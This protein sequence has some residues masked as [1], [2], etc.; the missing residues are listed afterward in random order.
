MILKN[1]TS[2]VPV[3]RTVARIE[4]LLAEFGAKA[5]GKNYSEG[6]LSSLTF[7]LPING[8][9]LLI[10]LP[11][12]PQAVFGALEKE[13]R[14][15]RADTMGRLREQADRTAWK[16]QQDWLEVELTKIRLSQTEPL[17]AFLAYLWDGERTYFQ[18]LKDSK[19]KGLL[20]ERAAQ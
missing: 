12:N 7:Q 16:I 17:Q 3:A 10:R 5:I 2:T 8:R 18:T 15:P 13:V 11:A 14:R 1:Y 6:K 4:E 19:F 9:D 20:P